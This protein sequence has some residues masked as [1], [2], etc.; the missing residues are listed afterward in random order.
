MSVAW[1]KDGTD[2]PP[3]QVRIERPFS[4]SIQI[5]NKTKKQCAFAEKLS[6]SMPYVAVGVDIFD[7]EIVICPGTK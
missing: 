4:Q 5:K 6:A 3:D 7:G 1:L 2:F